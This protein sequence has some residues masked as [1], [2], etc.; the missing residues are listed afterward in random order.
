MLKKNGYDPTIITLQKFQGK[1]E[2]EDQGFRVLDI[3][4]SFTLIDYCIGCTLD[5][6][7]EKHADEVKEA[8]ERNC[9]DFTHFIA[10]DLIYQGWF[11]PY[12]VGLRRAKLNATWLHWIHSAPVIRPLNPPYPFDHLYSIFPRERLVYLN[13]PDVVRAAEMYG[14]FPAHV[15][16]VPNAIDPRTLWDLH[17]LTERLLEKY[18][19]LNADIVG[20]YPLSSTR[21]HFQG[22]YENQ[23]SDGK[24]LMYAIRIFAELKKQ[25][26][27]VRYIICNAHANAQHE[28]DT[29]K[30]IQELAA[31]L[32]L[33]PN[34]VIFT[35]LEEVPV[36][37]HGVP[38]R[39]VS[40][41]FRLSDLFLLPSASE[42]CSL[43]LLEAALSKNLMVL[44]KSFLPLR[45]QLQDQ[46]LYYEFGRNGEKWIPAEKEDNY[47]REVALH[48]AAKL[49]TEQALNSFRK[50]AKEYNIDVIF[51]KHIEPLLYE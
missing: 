9:G 51:K 12:N 1:K 23:T 13:G 7:F 31:N 48:I 38:R 49:N 5:P 15:R 26:R 20:V 4:P 33:Y 43:V 18:E 30:Q 39:V 27:S 34:E 47:F 17:P 6:D 40:E 16:V 11:L 42:N 29:I 2:L 50:I 10:H 19:L 14:I 46:A 22:A 8:L 25:G 28:K 37:E 32:G 3:L 41:L 24:N 21:M 44:N 35:S 45:G 36:W